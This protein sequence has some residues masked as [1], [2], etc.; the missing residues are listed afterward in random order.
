MHCFTE[1]LEVA[2]AAL[3]MGFYISFSGIVTFKNA[4]ELKEVAR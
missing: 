3:D 2:R 4:V 1:T